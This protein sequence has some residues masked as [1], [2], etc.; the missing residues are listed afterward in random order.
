[1]RIGSIS[2]GS[3]ASTITSWLHVRDARV[4]LTVD[5]RGIRDHLRRGDGRRLYVIAAD[6]PES[7]A[8]EVLGDAGMLVKPERTALA[9]GFREALAGKRPTTDLQER[10]AAYDW[11]SA[12]TKQK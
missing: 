2:S 11:G 3:W 1:M 7:T 6:H 9:A 10:A 5:P 12:A 8:S 4:R